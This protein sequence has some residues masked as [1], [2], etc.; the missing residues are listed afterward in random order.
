V[1]AVISDK[2]VPVP[3]TQDPTI[4]AFYNPGILSATDYY[5][6]G[7]VMPGRSVDTEKYRYGFNGQQKDDEIAHNESSGSHN[8]AEFWMYDTRTARRWN[9]DPIFEYSKSQYCTF[10]GNPII[11]VDIRGDSP[12]S[13]CEN[14]PKND[15]DKELNEIVIE[16]KG[17]SRFRRFIKN[18]GLSLK[19]SYE[20]VEEFFTQTSVFIAGFGN[21]VVSNNL[22]GAGRGNPEDFGKY[23]NTARAGQTAGD[24]LSIVQGGA[25]IFVGGSTELVA[26]ALDATGVGAIV[27]VPLNVAGF[28][29]ASHGLTVFS[30]AT[31]NIIEDRILKT[32]DS[33]HGNPSSGGSKGGGNYKPLKSNEAA[34]K[35]A[36][37]KGYKD[38]HDL[39]RS[40]VGKGNE[41][42]FDIE[43]DSKTG[44]GRLISKDGE[45]TVDIIE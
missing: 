36:R 29:I 3:D 26:V 18:I 8:F 39:K 12:D 7:M 22:L 35:Y 45:I 4:V 10:R 11:N 43:V 28:A 44:R 25:E 1:Q 16:A 9:L 20:N 13:Y 23:A 38:A 32:N 37:S 42:K 27:G 6:F 19:G 2:K 40:H 21:A 33:M 30:V 14:C 41:S 17:P 31:A 15:V 5:P 34:N 24:V